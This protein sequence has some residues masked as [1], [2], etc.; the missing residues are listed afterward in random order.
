MAIT[1]EQ[2][3]V[4]TAI[5]GFVMLA[6]FVEWI[7]W[8]AAFIYCLWKVFR[9]A[10]HWTVMLLAVVVG[11]VFTILRQAIFLSCLALR[12]SEPPGL[13]FAC[14]LYRQTVQTVI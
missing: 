14:L 2:Q 12:R 10:E 9:K 5:V 13:A 4:Y 1:N 3:I 7:L 6:A 8:L 11:T